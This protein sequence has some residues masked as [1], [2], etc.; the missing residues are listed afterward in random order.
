MIKGFLASETG[1]KARWLFAVLVVL[2]LAINGLNVVNS[3]V[4]RDFMTALE[5]RAVPTFIRQALLFLGVFVLSTV[6]A[7]FLRFTE[8]TLA[9]A[10]REWLSRSAVR[11]YLTPPVYHR[12]NNQLIANPD[13]RIADDVRAFTATSLSFALM[14]LNGSF[15][16]LAFSGVLWSISPP[17]FLVAV[18]YAVAG[19][20][21]AIVWGRPL[22]ALNVAQ[23]DKE[24]DF[25]AELIHVRE[26]ADSLAVARREDRLQS[27]LLRRI[28][29][30]AENLRRIIAVNRNLG[31]FTTGYN[32]LIQIIPA[33]VVAPLFIRGKVEFGVVTQAAMA[34]A[35]LVAAFSLI[36]NQF[37]AISSYAAV[38]TRLGVLDEAIEQA[39]L[40]PVL[41]REVGQHLCLTSPC[42]LCVTRPAAASLIEVCEGGED[43]GVI[44]EKLT[45]LS[46]AD[47]RVLTK[48]LTGSVSLG[49]RLAI[50]GPNDEAKLALFRATAGTWNT[51]D[52][53]L[54]RPGGDRMLFLAERPYLPPGTL[55][56][57]LTRAGK[58]ST[59]P[60][61][62]ILSTLRAVDLESVLARIGGLD[63]EKR[64][65]N[66][67]SLGEQQLVAFSSVLLTAPRFVF[68]ERPGTALGPGQIGRILNMLSENLISVLTIRGA[69]DDLSY[70]NAVLELENDGSWKWNQ[71]KLDRESETVAPA[72]RV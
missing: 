69:N 49:T 25:R 8:E 47:G 65:S 42:P 48:E 72:G 7:V 17:L 56:E 68:L 33:L 63:I 12:L 55:R 26:N 54:V 66:I 59:I 64:W 58:E 23:L 22:V 14:V 3:Y 57:I 29:D 34:F 45:L 44:F 37:Q 51:G 16:I 38:V 71:S 21:L 43:S 28:H 2:L 6:A 11:R 60:D 19:S 1:G 9:L 10:W 18:I 36:I 40:R 27:R 50:L 46:L 15:T 4:G 52:G 31:L 67:L 70:Y 13:E 41:T 39:Q 35:Q 30:L 20:L 62:R 61:E 32:Y 53:R 24:A 5:K